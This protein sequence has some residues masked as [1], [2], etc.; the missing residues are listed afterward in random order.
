MSCDWLAQHI[1]EYELGRLDERDRE[2]A[3]AHLASCEACRLLL[4]EVRSTDAAVRDALAGMDP[5]PAFTRA[6]VAKARRSSRP[7]ATIAAVG[8]AIAA[9]AAVLLVL[10]LRT[11]EHPPLHGD[12]PP[13]PPPPAPAQMLLAGSL[14]DAYGLPAGRLA[15]G[16]AYTAAEHAAIDVAPRATFLVAC[17]TQ[18]APEPAKALAMSVIC[19]AVLGQV[20]ERKQEVAV[21]LAP[22]LGG[23]IVRTKGGD[24][25]CTGFPPNRLAGGGALLPQVLAN[26]HEAIRLHVFT[27]H[28]QIDL[29]T[30]K[31]SLSQGDS[32]IISGGV[33]AGG[34]HSLEA[35][36]GELRLALG[37]DVLA[38]RRRYSE[39]RE[40]YARR[41]LELRGASSEGTLP[42]LAERLALVDS[43]L[44]T[45]AAAL[46]RLETARPELFEL[47][48]A[49]AEL[50][51]LDQL[52]DEAEE[53]LGRIYTLIGTAG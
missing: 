36:V 41:L 53:G 1:D 18:F 31:V 24:F 17:G 32:A 33:T 13:V 26:W 11:A 40:Q 28:L 6:V 21:E 43:L 12:P 15:P 52:R 27:G 48:A 25:Y 39:L 38:R 5:G 22:E 34:T 8:S 19:G 14:V 51:R 3:E 10:A 42:F 7:W 4:A 44:H 30:Q 20:D 45:H 47:D 16:H 35:R 37:E 50:E 9:A 29:G 2:R 46:A 23:A 49:E